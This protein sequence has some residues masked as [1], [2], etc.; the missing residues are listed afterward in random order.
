[1]STFDIKSVIIRNKEATPTGTVNDTFQGKGI[2]KHA[3]GVESTGVV[4]SL[5]AGSQIRLI[6][7]PSNARITELDFA[8]ETLGTSVLDIAVFFPAF[9]P[10]GGGNSV[11]LTSASSIISTSTFEVNIAGI[12]T[13]VQWTEGMGPAAGTNLNSTMQ[14]LWRRAGLT[15]DPQIDLDLG[16]TVRTAN[17]EAGY[18]GLRATYV[19]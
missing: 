11:A 8:M 14:P 1:M 9:L 6:S 15:S 10:Q 17:L 13:G 4:A 3:A 16:F 2:A 18:V 12:D 7:V 5:G 19:D